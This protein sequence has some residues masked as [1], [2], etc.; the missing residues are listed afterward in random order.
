MVSAISEI[1]QVCYQSFKDSKVWS[2]IM[3]AHL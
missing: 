3:D 2:R 1:K